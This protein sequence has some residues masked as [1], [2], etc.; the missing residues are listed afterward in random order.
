MKNETHQ[1][2]WSKSMTVKQQ[3]HVVGRLMKYAQPFWRYFG[4]AIGFAVLISAVNILLPMIIQ[5]YMDH[6]L[7][8]GRAD[9]KIMWFFCWRIFLRYGD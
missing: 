2:A 7:K 5:T 4:V 3:F 8:V 6:Y 1:S 9:L